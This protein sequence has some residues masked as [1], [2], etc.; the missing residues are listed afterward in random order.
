M[1]SYKVEP[2][3]PPAPVS[4]TH[5]DVYKRQV[6]STG[7]WPRD[8]PI[9]LKRRNADESW[10][11]EIVGNG[12]RGGKHGRDRANLRDVRSCEMRVVKQDLTILMATVYVLSATD[13]CRNVFGLKLA[14]K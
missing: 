12:A 2:C 7:S 11:F 5:L 13:I 6:W 14:L 3:D 1:L 10:Y 9:R 4:Y 8:Q